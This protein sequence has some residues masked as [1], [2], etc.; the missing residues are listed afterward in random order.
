MAYHRQGKLSYVTLL[1]SPRREYI[2]Q[3]TRKKKKSIPLTNGETSFVFI[4]DW[5]DWTHKW[6]SDKL[7]IN[8]ETLSGSSLF[9][10]Y[11]LELSWLAWREQQWGKTSG[12][13]VCVEHDYVF[14][15]QY[16]L[17]R[18][19]SVRC[20]VENKILGLNKCERCWKVRDA[21]HSI[22]LLQ[23]PSVC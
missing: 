19:L 17:H 12:L 21:A 7:V 13:Y 8:F 2:I 10:F 9:P 23:I 18:R 16:L 15:S 1:G 3:A 4:H 11:L 20:S 5:L 22:F 14:P 6:K